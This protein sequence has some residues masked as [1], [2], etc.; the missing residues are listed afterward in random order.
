VTKLKFYTGIG[1]RETPED[2]L[3]L[4]KVFAAQNA[5]RGWTL[6]SGAAPGADSAFESGVCESLA[7]YDENRDHVLA[8]IFLP[9]LNF[10]GRGTGVQSNGITYYAQP[11]PW[12]FGIAMATHPAWDRLKQGGRKLHARNVHQVLGPVQ[13]GP[14]AV[15]SKF[16]MCWTPGAKGGG[17]T[18][19][20]I[21]IAKNYGVPVF[22]LADATVRRRVE[23][24][25]AA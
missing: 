4:M 10:E 25:L 17:G 1:S 8:Q 6:R 23:A 20:A 9:W 7:T 16:V 5:D 2:V 13:H 15:I 19:Q 22:D 11:D 21:R 24:S 3:R 12:T 14:E 18:G